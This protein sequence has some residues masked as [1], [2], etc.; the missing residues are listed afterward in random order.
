LYNLNIKLD[1]FIRDP[2]FE[3]VIIWKFEDECN[4]IH[5]E[6]IENADKEAKYWQDK[7]AK[8]EKE[9]DEFF[10]NYRELLP[11]SKLKELEA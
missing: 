11:P 5:I 8:R 10:K 4:Y 9:R 7:V 2:L 3:E 1:K 6:L